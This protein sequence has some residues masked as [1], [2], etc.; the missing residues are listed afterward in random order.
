MISHE[1]LRNQYLDKPFAGNA[2]DLVAW[3]GAVQAQEYEHARWGLGLRLAGRPTAANIDEEIAAGRILRTHVLRPTWH[4]VA[5]AD[6]PWMLALTAPRVHARMAPYNR[7]LDL[8]AKTLTRATRLIERALEEAGCLTRAELGDVLRRGRIQITPVRLAHIAMHAELEAVICS[9]PLRERRFT[10]ALMSER[11]R[12]AR[13]LD[14]DESLGELAT[15]YFQSH[16]PATI[17]DF[18][19]WSG[20]KTPDAKR[21]AEI[22]RL[23]SRAVRG[24]IYW[25]VESKR[26]LGR[27]AGSGSSV[28]LLP[29]YDEYL[30]AYRDREQ[31]PHGPMTLLRDG[32]AVGYQHAIVIDGQVA[33][34]WRTSSKSVGT[35][36]LVP[37]RRLTKSERDCAIAESRRYARFVKSSPGAPGS[38][39]DLSPSC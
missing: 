21:S 19:W 4:F 32:R 7:H 18:V 28:H 37:A 20:L 12:A 11:A 6:L 16:G 38:Q 15:R 29:I 33:G 5:A 14:R 25:T 39:G 8:D 24:R 31:V 13:R 2:T 36:E 1:R 22:A 10:Y 17:R 35:V 30:V 26:P 27:R 3:M 34:T 9:G 23:S